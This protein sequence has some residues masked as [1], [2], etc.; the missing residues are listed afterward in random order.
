MLTSDE[1][2]GAF[3]GPGSEQSILCKSMNGFFFGQPDIC[4]PIFSAQLDNSDVAAVLTF[5]WIQLRHFLPP[6]LHRMD[7]CTHSP[8]HEIPELNCKLKAVHFGNV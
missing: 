2:R 6:P 3:K 4:L 5:N 7:P 8:F 1:T